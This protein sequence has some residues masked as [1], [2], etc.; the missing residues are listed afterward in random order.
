MARIHSSPD[1][2]KKNPGWDL[3]YN[4]SVS[5]I[6]NANKT[7]IS[8][9]KANMHKKRAVIYAE[10]GKNEIL[11]CDTLK[12]LT[13]CPQ[14]N[15]RGIY[16]K[17]TEIHN[18]A[19]TIIHCNAI[20][21]VDVVDDALANRLVVFPFR[22]L[23]RTQEKIATYPSN[24]PN[25]YLVNTYYKSQE[26]LEENK[27]I[28]MNI[29][30]RHYQSFRQAGYVIARIPESMKKLASAYMSDSDY[31]VNWYNEHFE[32]TDSESDFVSIRT[33]VYGALRQSELYSNMTKRERRKMNSKKLRQEI[34]NNPTL[35]PYFRLR[36]QRRDTEQQNVLLMHRVRVEG[37]EED[38]VTPTSGNPRSPHDGNETSDGEEL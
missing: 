7:G 37:E 4:N 34:Q 35:R 10:P 36:H 30:L 11:R 29:L 2:S 6:T 28:F 5:V 9:E 27:L 17:R 12:E 24:T 26:F 31:F 3:Y 15:G 33:D 13:G 22:S 16:S 1:S 32:R 25:L 38:S 14:I 23:F 21:P 19:T 20:P 8:Q 18:H